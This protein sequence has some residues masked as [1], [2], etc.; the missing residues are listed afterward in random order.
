MQ[1]VVVNYEYYQLDDHDYDVICSFR[2]IIDTSVK[3]PASPPEL[4]THF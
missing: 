2:K 3:I 4:I 1:S